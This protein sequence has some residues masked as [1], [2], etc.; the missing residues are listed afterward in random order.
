MTRE[1]E[2]AAR[3]LAEVRR[4]GGG[5]AEVSVRH[6]ANGL[7]RFA[8]SVIHQNVAD[9]VTAVSLRLHLDGRTVTGSTTLTG[10]DGLAGL[11]A[12]ARAS[13][14]L[15]PPDP[16]WPGLSPAA[17]A[18]GAAGYDDATAA[19]TPGDRA[20]AVR[21]FVAAADGLPTAGY[22]RTGTIAAA[23]ANSAGQQ[24]TAA[25]TE[26]A[27]DGIARAPGAD[28]VA[29]DSGPRL[30][31][32]DGGA[33]GAR[34]AAKA[35]AATGAADLPPGVYEVVLEPGAVS[36]VL[37]N[38]SAFGFNGRAFAERRSFAAPGEAQFDPAVTI[39]D[40]VAGG[41]L[42]F[43]VEGT[44]R[45]RLALVE[46]GVTGGVAHDRRTA[47]EAGAASTGHAG[48]EVA[49]GPFPA[50][51]ALEPGAG[52]HAPTADPHPAVD[53]AA[54]AL[55][56]GVERGLLVTDF[57]YTRVLD[58]KSLVVTGLTRNG[59]WLIEDGKLAGPVSNLRF[60]QSY[61]RALAP[62][63]VRGIGAV[64]T[65]VPGEWFGGW[66]SAPALHLAGW[67]FTGGAAG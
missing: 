47:A 35:R 42:P 32:L 37:E 6:A 26:A 33:L 44:P 5:D 56:A 14:E 8:N 66:V 13:A 30:G 19:A 43:D 45:G 10:D 1:L 17:P 2:L 9:E 64:P 12:R 11:V 62:G 50:Y 25:L 29:R 16:H 52:P 61:P 63:A 4:A 54:A 36:D 59:I 15:C 51:V 49:W 27:I 65:R 57:W 7:T 24:L 3:V 21:A 53:P 28:A 23:F 39:V 67:H 41:G 48:P 38:L 20:A 46:A 34:A 31:P 55:V 18:A 22:C 60:T 40:D 58:P